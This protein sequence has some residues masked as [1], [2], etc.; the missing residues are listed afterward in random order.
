MHHSSEPVLGSS[1]QARLLPVT[2]AALRGAEPSQ[3]GMFP[4][5]G[6]NDRA[7][8]LGPGKQSAERYLNAKDQHQLLHL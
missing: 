3:T 4:T 7:S 2:D 5:Y 8:V 6:L 1:V